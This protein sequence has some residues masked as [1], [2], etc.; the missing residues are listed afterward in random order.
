MRVKVVV[1]GLIC[2]GLLVAGCGTVSGQAEPENPTFSQPAFNPCDDIPDDAIR[3]IGLDPGTEDRDILG[4]NQP[5]W[6]LCAWNNTSEFVTVYAGSY[7]LGDI[8]R[9]GDFTEFT[10]IDLD[11][12]HALE[13]KTVADTR[14]E[15]C[16]VAVDARFGVTMVSAMVTSSSRV[17]PC[18]Y[19]R[20]AATVLI[21]YS[22]N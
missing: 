3:S 15:R 22:K 16:Y 7:A 21:P 14:G 5:G 12:Q 13:F 8:R 4:V 2:T 10:D 6:N 20:D 18:D 1:G 9:N 19:V 17:G 11:G